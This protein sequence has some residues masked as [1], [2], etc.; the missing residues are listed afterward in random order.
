V[1]AA[2]SWWCTATQG[3]EDGAARL[4]GRYAAEG[5]G[6]LD[7]QPR[8]GRPPVV[9]EVVDE[10]AVVLATL[11]TPP[12]KLGMTHWSSRLLG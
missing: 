8:P 3:W 4:R 9:D 11:G 10:V 6:G 7:D 2:P 1:A 12:G 5:I